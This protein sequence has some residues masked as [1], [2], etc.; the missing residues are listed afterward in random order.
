MRVVDEKTIRQLRITKNV[1]NIKG[2]RLKFAPLRKKSKLSID[3]RS[4]K[5]LEVIST[6]IAKI[7]DSNTENA[8][9]LLEMIR[10]IKIDPVKIPEFKMW[11]EIKFTPVRNKE[12]FIK[13]LTAKKIQ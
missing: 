4:A 11:N 10:K 2:E 6:E 9:I 5:A 8:I 12:G 1:T 7:L 3:E 13:E